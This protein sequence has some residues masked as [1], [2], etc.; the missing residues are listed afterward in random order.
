MF[1]FRQKGDYGDFVE[2]EEAKVEEWLSEAER[3]IDIIEGLI[4]KEMGEA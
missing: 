2:F 4:E 1:D 3:F